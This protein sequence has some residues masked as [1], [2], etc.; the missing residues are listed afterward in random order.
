MLTKFIRVMLLV[1][2]VFGVN[3]FNS[4][5][6][7]AASVMWGKTEL[8][9]GQ[10]GKVTILK[11]TELVKLESNGSLSTVRKLKVG[12]EFRVY[13]FKSQHGGLYGVGGRSYVR[14]NELA[15]YETPSKSKLAQ[16]EE[17]INNPTPV[18]TVPEVEEGLEVVKGAPSVFKNCTALKEYYPN[19]VMKGHPAY[20]SKHDRDKDGWACEP[21]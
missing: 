17:A 14:K 1:V 8:K 16:L 18:T 7:N 19:G 6:S 5:S 13:S 20:A 15:K 21:N 2:L 11:S 10:I 4:A 9:E 3:V 12:D